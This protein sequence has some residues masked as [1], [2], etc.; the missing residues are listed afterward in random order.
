MSGTVKKAD[1]GTFRKSTST[2]SALASM[3][4]SVVYDSLR[5]EEIGLNQKAFNYAWKGFKK[6]LQ[7]G[8]VL[9]TDYITI[10][11]FSQSSR[12]K[13]LYIIDLIEMKVF[14][15]TYVAHGRK[16]GGEFARSFSNRPES[17][18]S[19]LGFYITG[20]TYF[21]THGLSLQINGIEKGIN[22]KALARRIVVHGSEYVG[23]QFLE[24]NPFSGRS[25]GCP[26]VPSC[27]RDSIINTIKEGTCLFIYHPTKGYITKSKIL[28]G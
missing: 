2:H 9:N 4:A 27:D 18:K 21:G 17:N 8:K 11:D 28:N 26:A 5:L 25:Y 23:D 24:E 7:K 19:S 3:S 6:L 13:R 20:K 16:S 10:A 12:N 1:P 22:D 14:K 15:N